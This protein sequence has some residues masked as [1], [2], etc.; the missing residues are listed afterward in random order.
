MALTGQP[1]IGRR[2][3]ATAQRFQAFD[4]AHGEAL[5]PTFSAAGAAELEAACALA[6]AAFD[7]YRSLPPQR[8]AEFLEALRGGRASATDEQFSSQC[9]VN[10]MLLVKC[11][12]GKRPSNPPQYDAGTDGAQWRVLMLTIAAE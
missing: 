1:F 6:D 7:S 2:R 9:H 5:M 4:P 3:A 12:E 11:L 8:R 10:V